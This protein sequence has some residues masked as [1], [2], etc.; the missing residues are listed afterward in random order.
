MRGPDLANQFL[1]PLFLRSVHGTDWSNFV[2]LP[3]FY[4][5]AVS[6]LNIDFVAAV[7]ALCYRTWRCKR[8]RAGANVLWPYAVLNFA[9]ESRTP[10]WDVANSERV[11]R[12][13]QAS[14]GDI[15]HSVSLLK[16]LLIMRI[17][18]LVVLLAFMLDN[19]ASSKAL[20]TCRETWFAR[21]TS[22]LCGGWTT[23][24][25]TRRA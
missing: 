11:H 20:D 10:F 9:R 18:I 19:V 3:F 22:G 2:C 6:S 14:A 4:V 23:L 24:A 5:V 8:W 17:S 7:R 1:S 13:T 21:L 12:R 25:L 16:G 15:P